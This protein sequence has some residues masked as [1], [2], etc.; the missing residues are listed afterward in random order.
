MASLV[1]YHLGALFSRHLYGDRVSVLLSIGHVT[2]FILNS[3]AD[4]LAESDQLTL[5]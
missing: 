2:V 5:N 3:S 1:R 4:T